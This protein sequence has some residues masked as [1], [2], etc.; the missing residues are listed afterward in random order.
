MIVDDFD[1]ERSSSTRLELN[2]KEPAQ[3]HEGDFILFLAQFQ[4]KMRA[5]NEI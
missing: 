3:F 4:W 5:V 2:F 1:K